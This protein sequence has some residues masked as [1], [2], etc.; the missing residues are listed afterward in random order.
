MNK[1]YFILNASF[2]SK[3]LPRWWPQIPL[4]PVPGIPLCYSENAAQAPFSPCK[5]S[6]SRNAK[7]LCKNST[8]LLNKSAPCVSS[9]HVFF[10][11][12]RKRMSVPISTVQL[13]KRELHFVLLQISAAKFCLKNLVPVLN[14]QEN[15]LIL[16]FKVTLLRDRKNTPGLWLVAW[17]SYV[18]IEIP[19]MFFLQIESEH[20]QQND[21]WLPQW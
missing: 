12:W 3:L 14:A 7:W 21:E 18:E 13:G 5:C 20:L 1:F 11:Y 6:T 17:K 9:S 8:Y 10:L 15:C 19:A 2:N 16:N 4:L